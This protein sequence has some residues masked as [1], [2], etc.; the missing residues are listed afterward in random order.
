MATI[1]F[2]WE[3]GGGL[4]HLVPLT[5]LVRALSDRGH[6]VFAALNDLN[7]ADVTFGHGGSRILPHL[8]LRAVPQV[9]LVPRV[10]LPT[11]CT[12]RGLATSARCGR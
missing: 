11:F 7:R 3:L 2:T 6:R 8:P 4:G 10:P 12:T 1:L 9:R 5:P